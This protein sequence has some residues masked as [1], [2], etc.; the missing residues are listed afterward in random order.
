MAIFPRK[1]SDSSAAG[2]ARILLV[3]RPMTHSRHSDLKTM[4][5][6]RRRAIEAQV[7]QKIRS[8][9]DSESTDATRSPTDLS[10]DPAQEDIDF[11]LVQMQAQTLDR[12]DRALSRLKAGEYGICDECEEEIPEARLRALPFATRCRNCQESAEQTEER[13][14]R[15]GDRAFRPR[16]LT[17]VMGL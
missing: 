1:T 16:G 5:E 10:D 8:F 6:A 4:L 3:C 11:A 2:T 17:E 9:R 7:Q 13:Q 12:I 15:S 14:R